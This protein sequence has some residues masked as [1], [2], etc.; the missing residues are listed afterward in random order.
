LIILQVISWSANLNSQAPVKTQRENEDDL[1]SYLVFVRV[2]L[3][4][5][6]LPLI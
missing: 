4:R 5:Y 6:S 1:V 3:N 2:L